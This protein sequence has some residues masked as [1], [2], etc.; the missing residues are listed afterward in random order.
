METYQFEEAKF[1]G[2]CPHCKK[3]ADF[4]LP[5]AAQTFGAMAKGFLS[6]LD[7]IVSRRNPFRA[8]VGDDGELGRCAKCGEVVLKCP[9]CDHINRRFYKDNVCEKCGKAFNHP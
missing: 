8:F 4:F 9:K 1:H 2:K 3:R 7:D 6:S 5:T